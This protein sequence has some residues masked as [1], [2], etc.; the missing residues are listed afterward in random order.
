M[1]YRGI[2]FQKEKEP[3]ENVKETMKDFGIICKE[4]P[5]K[6]YGDT[7]ELYTTSWNDEDGDDEFVPDI[8]PIKSYD[9]QVEFGYK[10]KIDTANEK[11]KTFL[12]YLTG[13]D[14][15]GA[16]MKVYDSY[17]RIGRQHVR[18]KSISDDIFVRNESEGDVVT[19]KVTF[20][21]NDPLTDITL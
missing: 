10:G 18:V 4:F 9:I 21:I 16:K 2:Y 5:F 20:K 19:F 17:T 14:G 3:L 6:L 1:R 12:D 8:L 15:S 7:K 11:I 13:K